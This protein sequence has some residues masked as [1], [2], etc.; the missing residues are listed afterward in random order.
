MSVIDVENLLSEIAAAEPLAE[1]D[2]A[3]VIQVE[4][5]GPAGIELLCGVW[6]AT[7]DVAR[8]KNNL[9]IR[10]KDNF[11]AQGIEIPFPRLSLGEGIQD[12]TI[13]KTSKEV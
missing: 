3:P 9:I 12:I 5:I 10:I 1:Q 13:N 11:A 2:H 4:N 8:L 7:A 6:C